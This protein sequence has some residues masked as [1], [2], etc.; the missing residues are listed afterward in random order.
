M[1]PVGFI[2]SQCAM[3]GLSRRALLQGATSGV[4]ARGTALGGTFAAATRSILPVIAD[5]STPKLTGLAPNKL[6][7]M[8]RADMDQNQFLV[9]GQLTRSIYDESATFKDQIDTCVERSPH[10]AHSLLRLSTGLADA[11]P[12][13]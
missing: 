7:E 13:N 3:V 12:N 4:L 11:V 5:A 8:V 2:L 9:T 10:V 1:L 6:A